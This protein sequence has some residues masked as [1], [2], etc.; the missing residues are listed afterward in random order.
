MQTVAHAP[1]HRYLQKTYKRRILVQSDFHN[2]YNFN[3]FYLILFN[4]P[5]TLFSV[6]TLK[7]CPLVRSLC[8]PDSLL[9]PRNTTQAIACLETWLPCQ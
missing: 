1:L 6:S 9:L 7:N 4:E 5:Y 3:D 2:F 8:V